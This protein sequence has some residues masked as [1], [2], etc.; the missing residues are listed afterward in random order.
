MVTPTA[1]RTRQLLALCSVIGIL[2]LAGLALTGAPLGGTEATPGPGQ[3]GPAPDKADGGTLPRSAERLLGEAEYVFGPLAAD[4][5]TAGFLADHGGALGAY[6]EDVSGEQLSGAAIVDRVAREHSLSPRLLIALIDDATGAVDDAGATAALAQP[7]GTTLAAGGLHAALRTGA[8]WLDD[9]Y[10]GLKMRGSRTVSFGDGSTAEG[11]TQAGAGHFAVARFLAMGLRPEDWAARRA[12]FAATYSRLFGDLPAEAAGALP[13]PPTQPPLLL[14]WPA[15]QRW[16][17]T[18]GPHGAWGIATAWGAVDFAPPSM[19]GCDA[20]PEWVVAA[21]PGLLVRSE[22]GYVVQD[23]DGDGSEATGWVLLYLHMATLGRSPAGTRVAAGDR[24]GHPSCEGGHSTGAHLHF[25]RRYNGEW[26]PAAGGS[27]PLNLS[28]WT[29]AG[30]SREYDGSMSRPGDETRN[31]VTSG[32]GGR[33]DIVSDNGAARWAALATQWAALAAS[34]VA[35]A[36]VALSTAASPGEAGGELSALTLA[37]QP[38]PADLAPPAGAA[39]PAAATGVGD[40]AP[41]GAGA[42]AG[43]LVLWLRLPGARALGTPF[44]V[45]V[46][47]ADGTAVPLMGR[48]DAAG[49]SE[50]VLLPALPPAPQSLTVRVPGFRPQQLFDVTLGGGRTTV[51]LRSDLVPLLAGELTRDDAIDHRDGLAWLQMALRGAPEADLDGNGGLGPG[52]L[53]S[54]LQGWSSGGAAAGG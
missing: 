47:G 7:F 12:H 11:P 46:R 40:L 16:Y 41:A 15:G 39:V 4:F 54:L 19:V 13:A 35:G 53:V 17:V 34:D 5:D 36:Q 48:T 29:F 20:A 37:A 27:A 52:D 45:E 22:R 18:G 1:N 26:Q 44:T 23:L 30:G 3:G 50:P 51:D 33:A 6:V 38:S 9:G 25:A 24:I 43:D 31:A 21:A 14:P 10:Y 28:G 49:Q 2:A 32:R 42:G 8:A